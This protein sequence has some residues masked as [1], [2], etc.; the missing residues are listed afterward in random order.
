MVAPRTR[1]RE[2]PPPVGLTPENLFVDSLVRAYHPVG[3]ELYFYAAAA[4][5][6]ADPLDRLQCLQRSV[7]I[8]NPISRLA[9]LSELRPLS[10]PPIQIPQF[11]SASDERQ[12]VR[13]GGV[14]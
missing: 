14:V 9:L 8:P 6:H 13:G 2:G 10:T 3:A 1:I 12:L 5:S 4:L 11:N 7:D